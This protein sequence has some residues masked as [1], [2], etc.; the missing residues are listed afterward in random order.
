MEQKHICPLCGGPNECAMAENGNDGSHCWCRELVINSAALA[1]VR[2]STAGKSCI[3]KRC[4]TTASERMG[5]Q[6][7][8]IRLYGTG[9]C[10][11]CEEAERVIHTAGVSAINIDIAEDG[12]LFERYGMRIPVLR[13]MDNDAEL[14]WPF[15]SAM[16]SG[17]LA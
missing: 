12:Q 15:N 6:Q 9:A 13:R 10:H 16:V 14:D 7:V 4:A 1:K 11:L 3:C 8:E 2:K 5:K 17:F